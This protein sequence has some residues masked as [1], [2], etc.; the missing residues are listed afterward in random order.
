MTQPAVTR[1]IQE[2]ESYYGIRLPER[3]KLQVVTEMAMFYSYAVHIVDLRPGWRRLR[4]GTSWGFP[5]GHGGHRNSLLPQALVQFQKTHPE[6]QVRST[7]SNGTVKAASPFWTTSWTL[8]SSKGGILH[9]QLD[10]QA[11]GPDRLVL[12]SAS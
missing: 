4:T 10:R 7:I 11:I 2:I 5:W 1:A 6:L 8:P 12:D 3:M 9:D